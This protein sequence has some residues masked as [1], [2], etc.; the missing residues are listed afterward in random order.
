MDRN[1]THITLTELIAL[2][3][4][5]GSLRLRASHIQ[6]RQTGQYLSRFKG[7][8]MEFDESRLYQPG[9]DVRNIDWR[10]TARTGN[11]HTKLFHEERERPVFI[12]IDARAPMFFATRGLFKSVV[13]A[14][15]AALLAWAAH[16]QGDRLGGIIFSAD[17]H[18][19]LKPRRGKQGVLRLLQALSNAAAGRPEQIIE[20]PSLSPALSRLNRI[21]HPGSLACLISDFRGFDE[22][23]ESLLTQI[24]R[25]NDVVL[26]HVYDPLEYRLPENGLYRL[27]NGQRTLDINTTN[28]HFQQDYTARFSNRINQLESFSRLHRIQ[29]LQCRTDQSPQDILHRAFGFRAW[30]KR[31]AG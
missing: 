6:A 29:W 1:P 18:R 2:N 7:R 15:I 21:A 4:H 19:E 5:A 9:D 27:T 3:Q 16:Q 25:H 8:G 13:A 31:R 22:E 10:V 23:S 26:I 17:E 14:E 12:G 28:E 30:P 24:A 11:T 20:T